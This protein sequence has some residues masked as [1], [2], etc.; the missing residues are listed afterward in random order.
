MDTFVGDI[1]KFTYDDFSKFFNKKIIDVAD[2]LGITQK[3]LAALYKKVGI[4][5][6][7]Y[8]IYTSYKNKNPGLS[9]ENILKK[10]KLHFDRKKIENKNGTTI[11]SNDPQKNVDFKKF[12]Y[13]DFSKYFDLSQ[14]HAAYVLGTYSHMFH[15]YCARVGIT[16]WPH[17]TYKLLKKRHPSWSHENILEHI[18]SNFNIKE[19]DTSESIPDIDRIKIYTHRELFEGCYVAPSACDIFSLDYNSHNDTHKTNLPNINDID[20]EEYIEDF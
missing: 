17:V 9:H 6:W 20:I 19:I 5:R 14:D 18:K 1:E 10:I 2:F 11:T 13:D 15:K 16:K 8:V 3:K 12:T 4:P 7:P